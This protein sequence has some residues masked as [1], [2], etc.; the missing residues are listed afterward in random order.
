MPRLLAGPYMKS[1]DFSTP[2]VNLSRFSTS[3]LA[4]GRHLRSVENK[5]ESQGLSL[6]TFT[7]F[8]HSI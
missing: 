8:P 4:L 5:K 7:V 1:A 3:S 2:Y 6:V